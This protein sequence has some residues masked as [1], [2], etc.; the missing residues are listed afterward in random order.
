MMKFH[1]MR[2][3][4]G[5][6][7]LLALAGCSHKPRVEREIRIFPATV[8]G[9]YRLGRVFQVPMEGAPPLAR[10]LGLQAAARAAYEGP[11]PMTVVLYEMAN[12]TAAFELLQKFP[13]PA[14]AEAKP[15]TGKADD[16]RRMLFQKRR[17]FVVVETNGEDTAP[18]KPFTAALEKALPI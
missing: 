17:Y 14:P 2:S 6:L 1:T 3:R 13:K 12:D 15:K 9:G 7:A 10:Q 5:L 18:L 11:A 8:E 16:L 4:I